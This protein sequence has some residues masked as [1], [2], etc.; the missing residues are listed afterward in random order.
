LLSS[1][2]D[3]FAS[4]QQ[5]R[6]LATKKKAIQVILQD[7]PEAPDCVRAVSLALD[8]LR[9]TKQRSWADLAAASAAAEESV[10]AAMGS[11]VLVPDQIDLVGVHP[12][13]CR[14]GCG[15][16][17]DRRRMRSLREVVAHHFHHAGQVSARPR[18]RGRFGE[19]VR[20]PQD[21]GP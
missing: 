20:C 10:V 13:E 16:D 7:D 17:R 5:R 11:V 14:G 12:L 1:T 18:L 2:V 8:L 19:G 21:P 15:Q 6:V 4:G 9:H 3:P